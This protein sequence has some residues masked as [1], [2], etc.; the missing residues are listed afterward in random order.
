MADPNNPPTPAKSRRLAAVKGM[1]D[2]FPPESAQWEWFEQHVRD[3]MR[4]FA[5]GSIRTPI[6]EHTQLF[7]KG[8]GETTDI[9]EKCIPS[10]TGSTE[11]TSPCGRRTPPVSCVRR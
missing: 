1:N 3:V 7:V 10:R 8:T 2:I 4:G 9:V 5:Y 6:L 11:K